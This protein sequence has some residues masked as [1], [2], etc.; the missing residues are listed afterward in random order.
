MASVEHPLEECGRH[1]VVV[2]DLAQCSK[3]LDEGQLSQGAS[4]A[5]IDQ[6]EEQSG[7]LR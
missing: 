2:Q 6:L 5:G 1:D 3:L 7:R 4:V